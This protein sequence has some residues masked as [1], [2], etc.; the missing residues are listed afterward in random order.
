MIWHAVYMRMMEE[1]NA[2]R[3]AAKYIGYKCLREEQN[4]LVKGILSGRDVA[5]TG[6]PRVRER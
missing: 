6:S 1:D 3:K 2:I 4:L 5:V